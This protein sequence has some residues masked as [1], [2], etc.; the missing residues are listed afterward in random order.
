[1]KCSQDRAGEMVQLVKNLLCKHEDLNLIPRDH[2][3][4]LSVGWALTTLGLEGWTI[5]P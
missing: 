3:K 4:K 1:M 2:V 5:Q